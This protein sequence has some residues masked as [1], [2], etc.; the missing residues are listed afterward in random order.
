MQ[1]KENVGIDGLIL[2]SPA[3]DF[4]WIDGHENPLA[5]AAR[6]PSLAASHIAAKDRANLAEAEAYASG[7]YLADLLRGPGDAQAQQRIAARISALTGLPAE[8]VRR[9]QG[10]I[11]ASDWAFDSD[12]SGRS[13]TSLYD[14]VIVGPNPEPGRRPHQWSDPGLDAMRA[15]LGSAMTT[16]T[17]DR[18]KW[19]VETA[20]YEIL[21]NQ[22]S[23]SWNWGSGRHNLETL[24]DLREARALDPHLKVFVAQGLYD[25]V[26]PYYGSKL[27]LDLTQTPR[28]RADR[29]PG[30]AGGHMFYS[31]DSSRA[32]LRDAA[33]K[34]ITGD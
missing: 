7:D 14:G 28:L 21:D 20:R 2:I 25:L 27:L 19:P 33:R 23:E 34:M 5:D 22:I 24:S 13:I 30:P 17:L 6:L 11:R 29:L 10:R 15:P 31:V 4:G 3:L 16:L 8:R 12:P 18:L 1:E 26:I 9:F 32:A